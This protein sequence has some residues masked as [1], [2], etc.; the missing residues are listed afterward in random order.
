MENVPQFFLRIRKS[1]FESPIPIENNP[2]EVEMDNKQ[3][4]IYDF[5]EGKD[6]KKM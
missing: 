6:I 5:I 4:E 1:D 3:P 2:I